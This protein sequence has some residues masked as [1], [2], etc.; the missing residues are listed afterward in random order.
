MRLLVVKLHAL[1]DL[2][3]ITPALNRLRQAFPKAYITLLTTRWSAPAMAGNPHLNEIWSVADALFF[4]P[5]L[6][7]LPA[8][9]HLIWKLRQSKQDAAV[10]FHRYRPVEWFIGMAGIAP[11]FH[12]SAGG[13]RLTVCLD[14]NRHSALTACE[15]AD[16]AIAGLRGNK[17]EPAELEAMNYEW[18]VSAGE[19]TEAEK[20]IQGLGYERG[21]FAAIFPG[22]A[23][24]PRTAGTER[25]WSVVGFASLA[26]QLYEEF[27]LKTLFMGGESDRDACG[28]AARMVETPAVNLCGR[29]RIRLA[30]AVVQRAALSVGNDSGPLHMAAAVGTPTVGI[31]GPTGARLKL[32][33][34]AHCRAATLGLPCSPCYFTMFKG[35]IFPAIRCLEELTVERVM[36]AARALLM[37]QPVE[38]GQR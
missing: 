30:A 34:G 25:R 31:F 15:L 33:P 38:R 8:T 19:K 37:A 2:V 18:F 7:T 29:M 23:V 16:L 21:G 24:N 22:G 12:F 35:C 10:I 13:G 9:L 5:K 36:E 1:G 27:G 4:A 6:S 26:R 20:L 17:Q 32:P 28:A 11:R 14:E 3:I